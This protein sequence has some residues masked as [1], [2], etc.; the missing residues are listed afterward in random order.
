M[1]RLPSEADLGQLPSPQSSRPLSSPNAAGSFSRGAAAFE[2]A[3][4]TIGK[5]LRSAGSDLYAVAKTQQAER[6][7]LD[8]AKAE[9]E[10]LIRTRNLR[11]ALSKESDPN[12]LE[13]RYRPQ[14]EKAREDAAALIT[15]PQKRELFALK[16]APDVESHTIAVRERASTL[17]R[18]R[19]IAYVNDKLEQHRQNAITAQDDKSRGELIV[20]GNDLITGLETA[21]HIDKVQAQKLKK[22]W[23]EKYAESAVAALPAE[24]QINMLRD[25]PAS[26]DATLDRIGGIENAT[27]DPAAK[28]PNSSATGDFQFV[29]GTWLDTIRKYR[30]DL[31]E[32]RSEKD[33]LD[34]RKDGKLSREMA[35]YLLDENTAALG[36]AGIEASPANLYLAHFLGAGDAIKVLQQKDAVPVAGLIDQ[37]SIDSN[38]A[39]LQGKTTD[40]V[41]EWANR[42]MGGAVRGTGSMIDFIPEDRRRVLLQSAQTKLAQQQRQAESEAATEAY[43]VREQMKDDLTSL[44][45]TGKGRDDLTEERIAGTL[46]PAKAQEWKAAR[47]D[48]H[49]VYMASNDIHAL[50]ESQIDQRLAAW[51]PE[52]GSDGFARKQK[53]YEA[54]REEAERV[55]T[56]RRD[57]PAQSVEKNP[58]VRQARADLK[59]DDPA[60]W[61]SLAK[62]RLVAQ[63]AAG[64]EEP[65]PLTKDE[66][67]QMT[68]GLRRMLPGQEKET[69]RGIVEDMQKKFGDD[70]DLA[71][72]Y[73][74]RA[75]KVDAETAQTAARLFRK[76]G[77]GEA[78]TADDKAEVDRKTEIAAAEKA[79]RHYPATGVQGGSLNDMGEIPAF[80]SSQAAKPAEPEI[81]P[82]PAKAIM[83][84]RADPSLAADFDQKFG[85]GAAKKILDTFKAR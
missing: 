85:K 48:A 73:A 28:N 5:S 32:G 25:A 18:D 40:S 35:G 57:D 55:R 77:N 37:R 24:K 8:Y 80:T 13:E 47:D 45:T 71:L 82:A 30:P 4:D 62:A 69:I 67:L 16:R 72:S 70:A 52:P 65:S 76:I 2:D 66:A 29:K 56:L 58:I 9:S 39:V 50:T 19:D 81:R 49:S 74:L 31:A 42:K 53:V 15:D 3:G 79:I 10:Y 14:F 22:S 83:A 6:N 11:D 51:M 36:K 44:A 63:E 21:G 27:G 33:I 46:G 12:G 7:T 20:A 1:A 54:V 17:I 78:I 75:H 34:L 26:R 68:V 61:Q 59:A 43:T 64:V 41:I 60:S 38:R 23:S 84:L